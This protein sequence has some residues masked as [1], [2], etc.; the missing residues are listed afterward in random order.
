MA[1][2]FE[3]SRLRHCALEIDSCLRYDVDGSFE[4]YYIV[5]TKPFRSSRS[6]PDFDGVE[7]LL[8]RSGTI[9]L[10]FNCNDGWVLTPHYRERW[11]FEN[12]WVPG[13]SS[14]L[15]TKLLEQVSLNRHLHS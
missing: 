4:L 11:M 14:W 7:T 6:D 2:G 9:D 5:P 10:G 12:D 1:K 15:I 3:S 8:T 13:L